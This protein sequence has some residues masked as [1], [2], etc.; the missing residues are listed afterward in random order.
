MIGFIALFDRISIIY[1]IVG[2]IFLLFV[3]L[4]VGLDYCGY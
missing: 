4:V 1:N 3:G 2:D